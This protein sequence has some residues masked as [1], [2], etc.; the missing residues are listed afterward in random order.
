VASILLDAS[1]NSTRGKNAPSAA[2]KDKFSRYLNYI[3]KQVV[4]TDS[5]QED[6]FDAFLQISKRPP[7]PVKGTIKRKHLADEST[8][9]IYKSELSPE[10]VYIRD[11]VIAKVVP[12]FVNK[13]LKKEVPFNSG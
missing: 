6:F 11:A 7:V 13:V 1:L 4:I 9:L 5:V 3:E 2:D 12:N 8:I 10:P